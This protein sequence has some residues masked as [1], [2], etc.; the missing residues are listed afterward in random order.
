MEAVTHLS[1]SGVVIRRD[2]CSG[3]GGLAEFVEVDLAI[4][5]GVGQVHHLGDDVVGH[6]LAEATEKLRELI[7]G[8][9]T[10][11]VLVENSAPFSR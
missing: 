1:G 5:V 8:D 6:I 4:T 2:L 9:D 10:V 3:R 7:F 11:L